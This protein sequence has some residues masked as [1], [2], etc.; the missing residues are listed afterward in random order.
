MSLAGARPGKESTPAGVTRRCVLASLFCVCALV[1]SVPGP[2][3][4]G[5]KTK[6]AKTPAERT[7]SGTVVNSAG[8]PADA[9]VVYLQDTKSMVIRSYVANGGGN[10]HFNQISSDTDYDVWAE[11]NKHRSKTKTVSMFSSHVKFVFKL[12]IKA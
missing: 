5:S 10:F 6:T 9:A 11:V 1:C 2:A 7:I 8:A 3:W 4:A 12:K